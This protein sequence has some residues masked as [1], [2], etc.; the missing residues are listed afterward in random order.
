MRFYLAARY[1][2][3]QEILGYARQLEAL[4]HTFTSRWLTQDERGMDEA[5]ISMRDVA[6]VRAAE[7]LIYFSEAPR[8]TTRGGRIFEMGMAFE[9]RIHVIVV[10][11]PKEHVF[12][13]HPFM[14]HYP[15]FEDLRDDL[16]DPR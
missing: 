7:A 1:T 15:T 3:Q 2:R 5:D 13:S 6:D 10:G 11:E 4:G 8:T 14:S 9:R 16:L 12:T